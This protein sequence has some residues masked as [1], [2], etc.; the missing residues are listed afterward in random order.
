MLRRKRRETDQ[1]G[2]TTEAYEESVDAASVDLRRKLVK[3]SQTK[4]QVA[5]QEMQRLLQDALDKIGPLLARV[6]EKTPRSELSTTVAIGNHLGSLGDVLEGFIM[7][8]AD[9]KCV[10]NSSEKQ[11]AARKAVGAF[12]EF[13]R[14]SIALI[15]RGELLEYEVG[16]RMLDNSAGSRLDT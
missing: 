8:E 4:A 13:L 3:V 9:P 11:L 2:Q 5:D 6:R 14:R 15:E 1:S 7:I 16:V 12:L 10:E